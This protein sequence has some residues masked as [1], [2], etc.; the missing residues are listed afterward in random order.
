RLDWA[1]GQPFLAQINQRFYDVSCI[2]PGYSTY[3]SIMQSEYRLHKEVY[4]ALT[5]CIDSL[6]GRLM[7]VAKP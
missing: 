3:D 6:E 2:L 5:Q 7:L 1:V 4:T